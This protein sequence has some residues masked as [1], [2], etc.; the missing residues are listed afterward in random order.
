MRVTTRYLKEST[1]VASR[2]SICSVTFI[3]PSSAPM[4]APIRP[5]RSRPAVSGP[6]SLTSAKRQASGDHRF[7]AEALER[8][9]RV[10][11]QHD[12]DGKPGDRNQRDRSHTELV[13]LPQRLARFRRAG[14]RPRGRCAPR[15]AR[16]RRTRR[17]SWRPTSRRCRASSTATTR[18]VPRY[19]RPFDANA[20]RIFA[21]LGRAGACRHT[22]W[23]S[24]GANEHAGPSFRQPMTRKWQP[25][26]AGREHARALRV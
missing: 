26:S 17:L 9:A 1:A 14:G 22:G 8:R 5:E 23:L 25:S 18:D 7:G 2:A 3:A 4:P 24:R 13:Q 21:D 20:V 15:T 16:G 12:A 6:V 11:R 10:H 19:I